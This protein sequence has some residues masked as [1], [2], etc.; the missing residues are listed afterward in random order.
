MKKGIVINKFLDFDLKLFFIVLGISTVSLIVLA[1]AGFNKE[2]AYS[3][4]MRKQMVYIFAG[5]LLFVFLNLVNRPFP[6]KLS[7]LIYGVLMGL[8]SLV[9]FVG[10]IAGGSQRWIN[11]GFFQIQP[12]ETIKFGVIILMAHILASRAEQ[13]G[14]KIIGWK[15]M[16]LPMAVIL[17]PFG[18]VLEQPDLGTAMT[19]GLIGG[20]MMLFQGIRRWILISGAIFVSALFALAWN[21]YFHDYQKLR[22]INLFNPE[23][24]PRASGYHALQS[25]IA[26]GSGA[27]W[28]KGFLQGTQ[29]Q[30]RFLPEQ[31]TDFIFSVLAEEWGFVGSIILLILYGLLLFHFIRIIYRST[32]YFAIF[33]TVGVSALIFWQV[34]INMG[35]VIGILPVVGITLPLVSYGGSSVLTILMCISLVGALNKKKNVYR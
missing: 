30:L 28:G 22:V 14:F 26:V 5:L 34:F 35:M 33:V 15:D 18:L 20:S 32:D 21:F 13:R 31:T 6:R 3:P 4:A 7:W 2:L 24:D 16:V 17:V 9:P 11:L 8:L 23:A 29:T 19:I 27:F 10:K 1:S 25:K 12:S